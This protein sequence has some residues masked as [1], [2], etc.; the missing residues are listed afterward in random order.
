MKILIIDDSETTRNFYTYILESQRI[1]VVDASDG[2]NALDKLYYYKDEIKLI[3]TDLNMPNLDGLSLIKKIRENKEFEEIPIGILST[4]DE[5]DKIEEGYRIGADF[6]IIKPV[7][8]NNF[9]EIV[10]SYLEV[11]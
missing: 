9:I 11:E 2:M 6:Y 10:K 5:K 7:E 1:D 3:L 4:L 8:S